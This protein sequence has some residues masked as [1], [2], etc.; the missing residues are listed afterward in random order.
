MVIAT[1]DNMIWQFLLPHI[2]DLQSMGNTVECVCAK[3]GFWFDEL[4]TKF[5][6]TC[7]EIPFQRNPFNFKT[8]KHY[9]ALKKLQKEQK[10]DLI[11][12][13]ETCDDYVKQNKVPP[14]PENLSKNVCS[15]CNYKSTCNKDN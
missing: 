3:T 1:T 6:L 10:Y 7:H 5:G 13:I 15:Y 14:K 9:K 2:K 12:L 4:Q 11:A 8:F